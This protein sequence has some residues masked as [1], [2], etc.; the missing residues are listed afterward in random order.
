MSRRAT[1]TPVEDAEAGRG[2]P[3][4]QALGKWAIVLSSI[5]AHLVVASVVLSTASDRFQ[6][7]SG[8][9]I[10]DVGAATLLAHVPVT[11]LAVAC[12]ASRGKDLIGALTLHV[13]SVLLSAAVVFFVTY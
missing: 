8:P 11:A 6:L 5:L 4:K 9:T 1:N 2:L 7:A 10:W 12:R 3:S 13:L